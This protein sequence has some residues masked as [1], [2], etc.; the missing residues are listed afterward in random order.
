MRVSNCECR[1]GGNS[2]CPD[3]FRVVDL[4]SQL[5][6]PSFLI[7]YVVHSGNLDIRLGRRRLSSLIPGHGRQSDL[8]R[9]QEL[10]IDPERS[11]LVDARRI[12]G[13]ETHLGEGVQHI[14]VSVILVDDGHNS[15]HTLPSE[16][17]GDNVRDGFIAGRSVRASDEQVVFARCDLISRKNRGVSS[18]KSCGAEKILTFSI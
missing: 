1:E 5:P 13:E 9:R 4:Q 17:F 8:V 7:D 18:E 2:T 6:R 10:F 15:S 11:A 14:P 12:R 16:S 3:N